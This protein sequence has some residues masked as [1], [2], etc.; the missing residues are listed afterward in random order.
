MMSGDED[1]GSSGC[2][3]AGLV[4]N[5]QRKNRPPAALRYLCV[6]P[7]ARST[8]WACGRWWEKMGNL[9]S[10]AR[11]VRPLTRVCVTPLGHARHTNRHKN[12]TQRA[13]CSAYFHPWGKNGTHSW[14]PPPEKYRWEV[15]A[16]V[17]HARSSGTSPLRA[18]EEETRRTQHRGSSRGLKEKGRI[19]STIQA[20]CRWALHHK[21]KVGEKGGVEGEGLVQLVVHLSRRG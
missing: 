2:V 17:T 18:E 7:A 8:P 5:G 21:S 6:A 4:K 12:I 16:D 1:G 9:M 10:H 15:A 13:V 14:D 19:I 20:R 11:S 3:N